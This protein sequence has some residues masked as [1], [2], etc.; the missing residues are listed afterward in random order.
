MQTASEIVKQ[1]FR[2]GNI[3]PLD[4]TT[5]EPV[6]TDGQDA[7]GLAILNRF[8]DSLY[9]LELGEYAFDW[10]VPPE[11]TSPVPARFPINPKNENVATNVW[12]YPPGNV[13]IITKLTADTTL[14]L[15]QSPDDG[16]RIELINIGGATGFSLTLDANGRLVRGAL[17]STDTDVLWSGIRLLYRAD[18]SDWIAI[19]DLTGTDVS[20]LPS[21]Y[22]DLLSVGTFIRLAPRYGKSVT[23]ELESTYSRMLKRLKTQYRQ[24]VPMPSQKPQPFPTPANQRRGFQNSGRLF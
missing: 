10:P 5:G 11:L 1:A 7:E 14:Y 4:A 3:V 15:P 12:P 21:I 19:A 9:G 8:I 6:T 22:D 16:A 13:R 20:L 17:T 18:L 2:E 24:R 23:P